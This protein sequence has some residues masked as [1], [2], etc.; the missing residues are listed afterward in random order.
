[1]DRRGFL[2]ALAGFALCP[3]CANLGFAEEAAHWSYEG[4][5]GPGHWGD[6]DPADRVCANGGQQSPIV[7]DSSIKAQLAP[8]KFAWTRQAETI[9]NNGHTI[10]LDFNDGGTLTKGSGKYT[11]V[12]FHFHHPSEHHIDGKGF[13]MEVHFVHRSEEGSLGVVGVMLEAGKRN[14]V[15]AKIV[16]T[17]PAV[18]GAPVEAA[19]GIDPKG[20]LPSNRGYYF[21]SG[22]LT[23]PPCSEIVDWMVLSRPIK[24]AMADIDTFAKLYPANARPVQKLERRL[25]LR[26]PKV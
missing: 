23:T 1:M 6:L 21:Y 14:P 22:S 3:V 12:Q 15:F 9:I 2:K 26:S 8:L 7:I 24:V 20:L 16:A 11:L 13:P 4:A 17:M 18:E 19:R 25:V 5:Q 10:Q